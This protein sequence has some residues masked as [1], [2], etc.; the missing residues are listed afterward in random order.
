MSAAPGATSARFET[1]TAVLIAVTAVLGAVAAWRAADSA[2]SAGNA[3]IAGLAATL[4]LE[5]VRA[6]ANA[7]HYQSFQAYTTYR[8]HRALAN[9]VDRDLS[10]APTQRTAAMQIQE[11]QRD[12]ERAMAEV[13]RAFFDVRFLSPD[14]EYDKERDLGATMAETGRD[15]QLNSVE[16]IGES[17]RFRSKVQAFVGALVVLSVSGLLY[18]VAQGLTQGFRFVLVLLATLFLLGG[19]GFLAVTEWL[20]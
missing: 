3:S 7:E 1:I 18:T 14:D 13:A 10:R 2:A 6:L 11:R 4:T 19:T 20:A 12:E 16:K 9:A 5:E 17:E 15:K 8:R